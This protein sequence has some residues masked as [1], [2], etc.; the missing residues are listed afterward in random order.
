[1][2][3]KTKLVLRLVFLSGIMAALILCMVLPAVKA[4]KEGEQNKKV[5]GYEDIDQYDSA[6]ARVISISAPEIKSWS[7]G[8]E[9]TPH[10]TATYKV[11]LKFL[12]KGEKDSIHYTFE[13]K[14]TKRTEDINASTQSYYHAKTGVKVFYHPADEQKIEPEES[15]RNIKSSGMMTQSHLLWYVLAGVG[16]VL[17]VICLGWMLK[18]IQDIL[19]VK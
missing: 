14:K 5:A 11:Q 18:T 6:T 13:E 10:I 2:S 1:M 3:K 19:K 17:G 8:L 7:K 9:E 4:G 12:R 15:Y 16:A